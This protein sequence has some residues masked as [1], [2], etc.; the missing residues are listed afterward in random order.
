MRFALHLPDVP[1]SDQTLQ[2]EDIRTTRA[3]CLYRGEARDAL[4]G[5]VTILIDGHG[6]IFL[7][8]P[9]LMHARWIPH[10]PYANTVKAAYLKFIASK[11]SFNTFWEVTRREVTGLLLTAMGKPNGEQFRHVFTHLNDMNDAVKRFVR[12]I[13]QDAT[14]TEADAWRMMAMLCMVNERIA[15]RTRDPYAR[16]RWSEPMFAHEMGVLLRD[17]LFVARA[18]DTLPEPGQAELLGHAAM[19]AARLPNSAPSSALPQL[20][21][22]STVG[23]GICYGCKEKGHSVLDC[24]QT[25]QHLRRALLRNRGKLQKPKPKNRAMMPPPPIPHMAP[26]HAPQRQYQQQQPV[27]VAP[28]PTQQFQPQQH[29]HAAPAQQ[30]AP[31]AHSGQPMPAQQ[32]QQHQQ[33]M[34]PE[35]RTPKRQKPNNPPGAHFYRRA[36]GGVVTVK[37]QFQS[38]VTCRAFERDE[39]PVQREQCKSPH[40]CTRCFAV[41]H[42][43]MRC[44]GNVRAVTY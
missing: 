30:Q 14:K 27:H 31:A 15:H 18:L 19:R 17:D 8:M 7:A 3:K 37:P 38:W 32:Q 25:P 16:L 23:A 11:G 28:G 42:P 41:D 44:P 35:R 4:N 22:K 21:A 9:F 24:A 34:H 33:W 12:P 5:L 6:D 20:K 29:G 1:T 10:L 43:A 2:S 13:Q 40:F 26:T 36:A 39:C